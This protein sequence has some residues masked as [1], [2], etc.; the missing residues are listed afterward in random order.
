MVTEMA[1]RQWLMEQTKNRSEENKR[2]VK[3]TDSDIFGMRGSF[4]Q[5][6]FDSTKFGKP[7]NL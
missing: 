7:E 2:E 1:N 4:R 3:R 6:S 5:L